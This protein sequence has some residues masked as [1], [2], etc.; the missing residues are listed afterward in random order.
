MN[1]LI[2]KSTI[3]KQMW[4]I[5]PP[6]AVQ[7]LLAAIVSATDA[8][9]LGMLNEQSLTAA[10]LASQLMQIYSFFLTALCIGTNALASQYWG[11]K[12]RNTV[13]KIL[14]ISLQISIVVGLVFS[15]VTFITPTTVMSIYTA[16]PELIAIGGEYL[17]YVS[18]AFLFMSFSQ[19]YMIIMKNTGRVMRSSVYGVITVVL[20]VALN[21][22][23]I[24]GLF[25]APKLGVVG[26]SV[27]TSVSRGVELILT[28]VESKLKGNISFSIKG[29]FVNYKTL[30]KKYLRYTIPSV[31][32]CMSWMIATSMTVAIL[33]HIS[34]EAVA[35]SAVA[36][37]VFNMAA[38]IAT[39]YSS[40]TGMIIGR[41]LGGGQ[42][43]EAAKAGDY[44]L[45]NSVIIGGIIAVIVCCISPVVV[46]MSTT[47]SELSKSYLLW[48]VVIAGVKCIG[49]F[50]NETLAR[51]LLGAGGDVKFLLI[52]DTI[53]MWCVIIP[54][55]L[56]SAFW[57]KLPPLI[58]YFI[59]NLDE[60]T[61]MYFEIKHYKKYLWAKDL[62]KKEWADPGRYDQM[63]RATIIKTMPMGVLLLGSNGRITMTN[64]AAGT[65]LGF[66]EEEIEGETYAT[67][68]LKDARNNDFAQALIDSVYDKTKSIEKVVEYYAGD[69]KKT[70]QVRTMFVEEEDANI[71]VLAMLNDVS[72]I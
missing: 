33:G 60:F 1:N 26:A 54:L 21:S 8:L 52:L 41:F 44:I 18:F 72:K 45:K 56:I 14:H 42:T 5:V 25:G 2:D 29:L 9:M 63:L 4:K 19:I 28:I 70:L 66:D 15:V 30:R 58:V 64:K 17:R 13:Q 67:F 20:N 35:A 55:G 59:I 69:N 38:S 62:T 7:N 24:F 65:L 49:K 12:D 47:L 10:T 46:K 16:D 37:I 71:G 22:I 48:M 6:M 53:N 34:N 31:V 61:K 36:L 39:A 27:A 50:C 51:G 23:L 11:K 40:S 32:Q 57:L 68:F 43:K 3:N